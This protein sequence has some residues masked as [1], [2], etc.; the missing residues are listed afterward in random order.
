MTNVMVV[1]FLVGGAGI[2]RPSLLEMLP[3]LDWD[4][5]SALRLVDRPAEDEPEV[6]EGASG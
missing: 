1:L 3:D 2:A 6:I 5:R 4:L